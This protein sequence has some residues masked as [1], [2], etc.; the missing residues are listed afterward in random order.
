M[1][2][3]DHTLS[4]DRS[5]S[6]AALEGMS[7]EDREGLRRAIELA[8]QGWGR[9]H[10]NPMV[11]CVL[12]L[13][14]EIVGEGWHRQFGGPHAEIEALAGAGARARGS[15]AYV[16]LEPC[17]HF[18]KTPPCTLALL[19]AGIR[20]VVYGARDPGE[21]SGGGGE[22]L[23][24][25][26]LEVLGPC[27]SDAE[28]RRE[29]PAFFTRHVVG[30]P[31]VA[32][33]LAV[34]LDGKISGSAGARTTVT[35]PEAKR[36]VHRLR[37]GFD[38]IL[39]GTGTARVD[40]PLLTVRHGEAPVRPP[41]RLVLDREAGLSPDSRLLATTGEAPVV[42]FVDEATSESRIER[43]E[44]AGADV[45]P[46]PAVAG[47][48]SLEAILQICRE[49]GVHSILCEGGGVLGNSLLAEGRVDRLYIIVA[50]K[51][52]G[53]GAVP[54]FPSAL[55]QGTWDGWSWA[56]PPTHLGEDVLL[57]MDRATD[58]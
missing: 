30:R 29:N 17:S 38:G 23:R 20:R 51:T 2:D 53:P 37:A 32:L 12:V 18:G 39:V 40:D 9:V 5:R 4:P 19:D 56:G 33:K 35:G 58:V 10:P 43:L 8:R 3:L 55:P 16:S 57:T 26:G 50:P 41:A 28:A 22:A 42:V 47:R 6:E 54:G 13:D 15:T 48:L 52:L 21:D 25:A 24:R 11:G 27:L 14:G 31:W 45:H 36:W 44:E 49:T 1:L 46:V 7:P 34:S